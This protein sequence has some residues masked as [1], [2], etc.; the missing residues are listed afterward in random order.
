MDRFVIKINRTTSEPKAKHSV[1]DSSDKPVSEGGE[2]VSSSSSE[3]SSTL[4]NKTLHPTSTTKMVSPNDFGDKNGN[5]A[6]QPK[7][8]TNI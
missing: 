2:V 8:E 5:F 3:S 1:E 4:Q 7:I 6:H